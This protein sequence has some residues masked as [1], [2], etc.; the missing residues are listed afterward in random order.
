MILISY[1]SGGFGNFLYHVL[2]EFASNTYKPNN[3]NFKFD[4]RGTSHDTAKYTEI[5]FHDPLDYRL[6]LPKT[7]LEC[8]ILCDNGIANDSYTQVHKHFPGAKIVR[9]TVDPLVR[10]VVYKTCVIKAQKSDPISVTELQVSTNWTDNNEPYA[11]REN[12]TLLYHNWP[13]KWDP[14]DGCLNISLEQLMLNPAGVITQTINALGGSVLHQDRL[15]DFCS[16]WQVQNQQ[17][18]KIYHD[19]LRIGQAL[20]Y[21]KHIDLNDITDLHDQGYIN[22]CI[23]KMYNVTIPVYD[24]RHWFTNTAEIEEMI[25][26]LK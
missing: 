18:F 3:S 2:T 11:A 23:E 25:K 16:S 13:F 15:T 1:P 17:Y 7:D 8:L 12:F 5:Y 20:V 24:Y 6:A 22:Y 19:W 14:M 21:C 4:T 9:V 26:C 10:P